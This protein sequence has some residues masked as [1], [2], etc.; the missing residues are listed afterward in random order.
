[1]AT[2]IGGDRQMQCLVNSSIYC[3]RIANRKLNNTNN[4]HTHTHQVF[5]DDEYCDVDLTWGYFFYLPTPKY[6]HINTIRPKW[7]AL[8]AIRHKFFF[9]GFCEC[10]LFIESAIGVLLMYTFNRSTSHFV[11]ITSCFQLFTWIGH[12]SCYCDK[13]ASTW[14]EIE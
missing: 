11:I 8:T 13:H 5:R 9:G 6:P 3:F 7:M 1:M 10:G 14:K 2:K 4:A 12:A